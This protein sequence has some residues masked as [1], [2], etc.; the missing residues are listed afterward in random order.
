ME[1]SNIVITLNTVADFAECCNKTYL[2]NVGRSSAIF[3]ATKVQTL[4]QFCFPMG[5]LSFSIEDYHVNF[6]LVTSGSFFKSN[7]VEVL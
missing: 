3:I 2:N 1:I 7:V 6:L 5:L 4:L